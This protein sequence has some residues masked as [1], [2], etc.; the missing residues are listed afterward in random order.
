MVLVKKSVKEQLLQM[1][2]KQR[3]EFIRN[4]REK[5]KPQFKN[6]QKVKQLWEKLRSSKTKDDKKEELAQQM[7]ELIKGNAGTFIYAHDT[8]RTLQSLLIYGNQDM[9]NE[10][11]DELTPEVTN[12]FEYQ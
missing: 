8:S 12:Y 3:K 5:K 11:F 9:R 10:L 2:R 6:V 4:L 7:F 1:D